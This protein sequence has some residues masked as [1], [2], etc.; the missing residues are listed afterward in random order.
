[1]RNGKN[2]RVKK[3]ICLIHSASRIITFDFYDVRIGKKINP[4]VETASQCCFSF[5]GKLC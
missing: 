5:F 2:Q 3:T 4:I 1:M